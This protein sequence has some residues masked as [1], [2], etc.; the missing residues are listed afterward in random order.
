MIG[1]CAFTANFTLSSN[2]ETHLKILDTHNVVRHAEVDAKHIYSM[3]KT[4]I[5]LLHVF[6]LE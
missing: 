5:I 4:I 2:S 3:F 1:H 6:E